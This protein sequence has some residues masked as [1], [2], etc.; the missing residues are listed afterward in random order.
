MTHHH[1]I[2]EKNHDYV[3]YLIGLLS[4]LFAGVVINNGFILIPILGIFGLM[5]AGFFLNVFVRGRGQA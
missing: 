2:E 1:K 3:Y 5:L 4:G